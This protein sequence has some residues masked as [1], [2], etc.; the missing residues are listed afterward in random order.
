ML[1]LQSF[2]R[3][4]RVVG[5]CWEKLKPKGPKGRRALLDP[6]YVKGEVF[7]YVGSIQNL[8]DLNSRFLLEPTRIDLRNRGFTK[9]ETTFLHQLSILFQKHGLGFSVR[10]SEDPQNFLLVI[11]RN[12]RFALRWSAG[13]YPYLFSS[14]NEPRLRMATWWTLPR[15]PLSDLS[16]ERWCW[17]L[18]KTRSA[19][20]RVGDTGVPGS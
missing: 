16:V 13:I 1:S 20:D 3:E 15:C 14:Y 6:V 10:A 7:A 19:A 2:L 12:P 8:K 9:S 18:Q 11:L 4:G 5:P 17:T